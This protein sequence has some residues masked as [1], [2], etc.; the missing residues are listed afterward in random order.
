MCVLKERE[1]KSVPKKSIFDC[2]RW[3]HYAYLQGD[4]RVLEVI[5]APDKVDKITFS[6]IIHVCTFIF[7]PRV[8]IQSQ[9]EFGSYGKY[10]VLIGTSPFRGPGVV[11]FSL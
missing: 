6:W 2:K 10:Q 8:I 1:R 3:E 7:S 5:L 9:K 4:G 11:S